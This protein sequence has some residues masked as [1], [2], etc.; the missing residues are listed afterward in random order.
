MCSI[1]QV[2]YLWCKSRNSSEW[3]VCQACLVVRQWMGLQVIYPATA[4]I[5]YLSADQQP[6]ILWSNQLEI[7]F[8]FCFAA[9]VLLTLSI[10]WM[11]FWKPSKSVCRIVSAAESNFTDRSLPCSVS[12]W[13]QWVQRNKPCLKSYVNSFYLFICLNETISEFLLRLIVSF[14]RKFDSPYSL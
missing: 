7:Y 2:K 8:V 1:I 14:S 10:T 9:P 3:K 6:F 4:L 11:L 13:R 12:M 5:H